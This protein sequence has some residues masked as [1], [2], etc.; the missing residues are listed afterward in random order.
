MVTFAC[1]Q[2]SYKTKNI[3]E[4]LHSEQLFYIIILTHF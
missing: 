2:K 4:K 3:A 1:Y